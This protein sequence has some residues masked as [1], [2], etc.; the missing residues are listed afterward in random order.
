MRR[1]GRVFI[2]L[3]ILLALIS[4]FGVYVV[5]ASAEPQPV[6]VPTTHLVMAIQPVTERSEVTN[7]QVTQ[8]DWPQKIATPIGAFGKPADVV[9]KL[10]TV[11]IYP[12]EP[13]VDKMLIDKSQIKETH[14]NAALIL[15]KGFVAVALPVTINTDV[16]EAIQ[17][18]DRVDL[19]V[20]FTAQPTGV[21]RSATALIVTQRVLQDVLILQVGPWPSEGAK[22]ESSGQVGVVTMQLNEQDALV[23][24]YAEQ[25]SSGLALALRP[26]NDHDL[27]NPEPVTLEYINKRFGY[28]LPISGQ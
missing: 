12:G 11:P 25:N 10:A 18:G 28:N 8:I 9:G 23:L 6:E 19:L 22:N 17:T 24:K 13:V 21:E 14:S 5:L 27:A 20:T 2:I 16:A 4:G 3:G 1:G 15:E 26:A 7:D